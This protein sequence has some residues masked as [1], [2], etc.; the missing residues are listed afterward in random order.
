MSHKR[1]I[2][3]SAIRPHPRK[4]YAQPVQPVQ[5]VQYSARTGFTQPAVGKVAPR[6]GRGWRAQLFETTPEM[7]QR[8]NR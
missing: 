1:A 6:T 5:Y 4:D 7:S 2:A 8:G 3:A